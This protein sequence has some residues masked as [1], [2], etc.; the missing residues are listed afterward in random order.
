M[1]PRSRKHRCPERTGRARNHRNPAASARAAA[2]G[3]LSARRSCRHRAG[4]FPHREP[5]AIE[6]AR[7]ARRVHLRHAKHEAIGALADIT[8]FDEARQRDRIERARQH[9]MGEMRGP[10]RRRSKPCR[11]RSGENRGYEEAAS[12]QQ[13]SRHGQCGCHGGARRQLGP[14]R[15]G[16][17]ERNTGAKGDGN[18]RQQPTRAGPSTNPG[19]QAFEQGSPGPGGRRR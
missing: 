19:P 10:Q 12:S 15:G 5:H 13:V 6:L 17:L 3:A 11:D 14:M 4:A 9:G 16:E 8:G 1:P 18:P 7:K 2:A